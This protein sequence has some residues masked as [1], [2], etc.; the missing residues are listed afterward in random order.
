[1]VAGPRRRRRAATFDARPG[2]L[3]YA[4]LLTGRTHALRGDDAHHRAHVQQSAVGKLV[5]A[6]RKVA[7][8]AG[9][10]WRDRS[11]GGALRDRGRWSLSLLPR[12]RSRTP[13]TV[14][15][16]RNTGG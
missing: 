1:A 6:A 7:S 12:R 11:F 5:L 4:T 10:G 13:T 3:R 14:S 16:S 9:R 2:R 15:S 8:T